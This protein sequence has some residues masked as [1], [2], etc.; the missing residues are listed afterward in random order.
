MLDIVQRNPF[1]TILVCSILLLILWIPAFLFPIVPESHELTFMMPLQQWA[2]NTLQL[3][4]QAGIWAS[5]AT[6]SL[7]V[8]LLFMINRKHLF[9]AGQEQRMLLLF[10][11]IYSAMPGS[12][13]FSGSQVAALFVLLSMY[14]LFNS[15]QVKKA[16]S[17][18]FLAAFFTSMASLFYLPAAI[19]LITIFIG[20]LISKPFE[21]RDWMA[22]LTGVATPYFYLFFHHYLRYG[23]FTDPGKII[24][25]NIPP[26]VMFEFT[27]SAPEAV[28]LVLL[29]LL[30]LFAFRP[31]RLSGYP[32]RI[33][34]IRM[35][36]T[37]KCML[38]LLVPMLLFGVSQSGIMPL[39]AI[40]LSILAADY[41]DHIRRRKMFNLL[42]LLLCIVIA[43]IRIL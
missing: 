8:C 40:P 13:Q 14:Y 33:K 20:I 18:L 28:L 5:F 9:V 3:Q 16:I 1:A 4:G 34:N 24:I 26:P 23:N 2:I 19:V 27:L 36:Q 32:V 21:W 35:R 29:A 30:A 7:T 15:I 22:Y 11:L 17:S 12:Q 43:G 10:V 42:V 6:L 37:L 38:L 39:M 41:Y 31:F 25:A